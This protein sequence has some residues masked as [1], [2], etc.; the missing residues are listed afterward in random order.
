VQRML[1]QAPILHRF[2]PLLGRHFAI[3]V[4]SGASVDNRRIE[5]NL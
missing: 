1:M 3:V 4:H 5:Y 2:N